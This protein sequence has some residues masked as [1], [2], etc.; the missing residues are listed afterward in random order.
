MSAPQRDHEEALGCLADHPLD[1]SRQGLAK[2]RPPCRVPYRTKPPRIG[3]LTDAHVGRKGH[4]EKDESKNAK[5]PT[6]HAV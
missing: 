4:F 6:S 1:A 3:G 2:P 5:D